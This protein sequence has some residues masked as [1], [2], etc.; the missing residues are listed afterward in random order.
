MGALFCCLGEKKGKGGGGNLLFSRKARVSAPKG[1]DYFLG[2]KKELAGGWG[3]KG[4][5][6]SLAVYLRF[7]KKKKIAPKEEC[8]STTSKKKEKEGGWGGEKG[9]RENTELSGALA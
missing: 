7:T 4:T 6:I 3:G 8:A 9:G 2:E 1:E 5:P